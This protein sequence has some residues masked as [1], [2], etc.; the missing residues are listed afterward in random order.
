[1]HASTN[2]LNKKKLSFFPQIRLY[3]YCVYYFVV[4]VE[5]VAFF[6]LERRKWSYIVTRERERVE[7]KARR[8][9]ASQ[10]TTS[11]QL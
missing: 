2:Y 1:M 8:S 7:Y 6:I 3:V 4:V 9:A 11:L 5:A 10:K